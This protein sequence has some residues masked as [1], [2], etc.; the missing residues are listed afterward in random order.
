MLQDAHFTMLITY[1]KSKSTLAVQ[2]HSVDLTMVLI[3]SCS[4][5]IAVV[6]KL[7]ASFQFVQSPLI[8]IFKTLKLVYVHLFFFSILRQIED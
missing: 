4:T 5:K 3:F 8:W 1:Y 7:Q 6:V 2:Y